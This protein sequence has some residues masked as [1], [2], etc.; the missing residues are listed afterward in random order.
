M[1]RTFY[2]KHQKKIEPFNGLLLSNPVLERGLVLAPVIVATINAKNSLILGISFSIITFFTVLLSSFV[3]K[4][5]PYTIR[6]ILYMILSSLIYIP[7]AMMM[8]HFF[9]KTIFSIGVFMPTLI[10]NSLIVVKSESRFHKKSFLYMLTDILCHCAGFFIVI[11][12]VGTLRELLY[13]GT[14]MGKTIFEN[15]GIPAIVYP[16]SGFIIVG[17]LAAL[18]KKIKISAE[19]SKMTKIVEDNQ[20]K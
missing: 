6:V 12:L 3:P 8:E 13:S 17:F 11:F 10:A 9:P 15:F 7:T 1:R 20:S 16:F 19:N 18:V 14:Y 5:I 4:K 2:Q